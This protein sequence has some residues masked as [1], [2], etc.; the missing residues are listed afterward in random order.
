MLENDSKKHYAQSCNCIGQKFTLFLLILS[1]FHI[2]AHT[3]QDQNI[4]KSQNQEDT[5][6][7]S[8]IVTKN[9]SD[10][11]LQDIVN[12]F[13]KNNVKV[14]F[15]KVRR[16]TDYEIIQLKVVV[17]Y[18]KDKL[19][20]ST[21]NNSVI[22][23]FTIEG[24]FKNG[25]T[26]EVF[27]GTPKEEEY[28][29]QL[30]KNLLKSDSD[31]I[32]A[33][34]NTHNE[35]VYRNIKNNDAIFVFT[36]NQSND[37]KTIILQKEDLDN[38]EKKSGIEIVTNLLKNENLNLEN[39][40][41][42]LNEKEVKWDDLN[43]INNK[44]EIVIILSNDH[45]QNESSS[46]PKK[47]SIEIFQDKDLLNQSK[48]Y[49]DINEALNMLK[50]AKKESNDEKRTFKIVMKAENKS[51]V[52]YKNNE[53]QSSKKVSIEE[54]K[55][56]STN[57]EIVA[58]KDS[59]VSFENGKKVLTNTVLSKSGI[60]IKSTSSNSELLAYKN[61]LKD[62]KILFEYKTLARNKFGMITGIEI[63]IS[64]GNKKTTATWITA[65]NEKGIPNIF[66]GRINGELSIVEN[67]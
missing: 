7:L 35:Q 2:S 46:H 17:S 19:E 32:L 53:F 30:N 22:N 36:N 55:I 16:S 60:I 48:T 45:T 21:K 34:Q 28:T 66:V 11:D 59:K 37:H 13:K 4:I 9:S 58:K 54:E 15:S 52:S 57:S 42:K 8:R 41:F 5:K 33:Y 38:S 27:F 61:Y 40:S 23:A 51:S 44:D 24:Q 29:L 49:E 25:K 47:A 18:D 43:Q 64:S 63:E 67:E 12:I 14:V 50:E 20:F 31:D 3:L 65:E 62:E 6:Y 26:V 56:D 39:A 1:T 10:A